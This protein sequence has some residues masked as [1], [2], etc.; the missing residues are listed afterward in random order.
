VSCCVADGGKGEETGEGSERRE[1]QRK[2][3]HTVEYSP[4]RLPGTRP[5]HRLSKPFESK[6]VPLPLSF[7]IEHPYSSILT[8]IPAS[9]SVTE[10]PLD[11][12]LWHAL[13]L[14]PRKEP[15]AGAKCKVER[16]E[17]GIAGEAG[18]W[19]EEEGFGEVG[20]GFEE[21]ICAVGG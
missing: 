5:G 21:L 14:Q 8:P 9:T 3:R 10:R 2:R 15:C 19:G 16:R 20:G 7:D 4:R 18:V 11:A 6:P 12:R 13:V 17:G 1:G